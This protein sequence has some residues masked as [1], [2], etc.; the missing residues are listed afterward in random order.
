MTKMTRQLIFNSICFFYVAS[1]TGQSLCEPFYI[2]GQSNQDKVWKAIFH[3]CI[4]FQFPVIKVDENPLI[5]AQI[6]C[7]LKIK[8]IIS[9]GSEDSLTKAE[10]FDKKGYTIFV[11]NANDTSNGLYY[12]NV[13]NE[14]SLLSNIVYKS[15]YSINSIRNEHSDTLHTID[16]FIYDDLNRLIEKKEITRDI[17]KDLRH[18]FSKEAKITYYR[19]PHSSTFSETIKYDNKNNITA[20]KTNEGSKDVFTYDPENKII[21]A[22]DLTPHLTNAETLHFYYNDKQLID[23]ILVSYREKSFEG[24]KIKFS[25][26]AGNRLKNCVKYYPDG[27]IWNEIKFNYSNSLLIEINDCLN[28]LNVCSTRKFYYNTEGLIIK[29]EYFHNNK[30]TKWT[31]YSYEFF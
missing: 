13:F 11:D 14:N 3:D 21:T 19:R 25:Y 27:K 28:S 23:S 7:K 26:D 30:M 6:V 22:T 17:I 18:D 16:K 9:K 10:Y 31:E 12:L 20:L 4:D 15:G 8:K 1:A 2:I 24:Y 5:R 29:I